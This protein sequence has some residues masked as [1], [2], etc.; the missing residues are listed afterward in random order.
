M[1][2]DPHET[3]QRSRPCRKVPETEA[4]FSAVN[5]R[6]Q[7]LTLSNDVSNEERPV[8]YIVGAP[9]SGTTL[10]SQLVSRSMPVGYITNIAARFWL[11][12]PVGIA[13][14]RAVLGDDFRTRIRLE[15]RHGT[16]LGPWGP[17]E[18]GYFWRHWLRL[19][20]SSTHRLDGPAQSRVD[21]AGL[22]CA[23]RRMIAAWDA[24][25]VMKNVI[26]GLQASLLAD[27][28]PNSLFVRIHRNDNDV[29]KSIIRCRKERFGDERAWWSVKPS[30]YPALSKIVSVREQV[31]RQVHDVNRDL[32]EELG[33]PG[34]RRVDVSFDRL[35]EDPMVVLRQIVDTLPPIHRVQIEPILANLRD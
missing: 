30:T 32:D 12:P 7:H 16:T 8:I 17:H 31:E 3:H 2:D 29:V 10:L 11:N 22:A 9:R 25:L 21:R 13:I 18:F 28:H 26:C 14:S 23:I 5:E 34:V 19:D 15:S 20:E 1:I 24:P 33:R 27:L 35:L 4:L 6:L